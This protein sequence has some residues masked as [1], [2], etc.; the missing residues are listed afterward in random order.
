VEFRGPTKQT[1][2]LRP[3]ALAAIPELIDRHVIDGVAVWVRE[4]VYRL[5]DR[6]GIPA[7]RIHRRYEMPPMDPAIMEATIRE[8]LAAGVG[9]VDLDE[10]TNVEMKPNGWPLITSLVRSFTPRR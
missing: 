8:M 5:R 6:Y 9:T 10:A 3:Y 4:D 7:D 1:S 2:G